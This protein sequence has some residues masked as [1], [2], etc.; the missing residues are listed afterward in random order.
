MP[1]S[2]KI[3]HFTIV[4]I[5]RI[6]HKIVMVRIQTRKTEAQVWTDEFGS[7]ALKKLNE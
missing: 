6:I 7:N 5:L 1:Q 3:R 2:K 4:T